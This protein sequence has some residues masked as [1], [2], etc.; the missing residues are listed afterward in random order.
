MIYVSAIAKWALE[1]EAKGQMKL[2]GTIFDF[3]YET[4]NEHFF[5]DFTRKDSVFYPKGGAHFFYTHEGF[6]EY[7]KTTGNAPWPDEVNLKPVQFMKVMPDGCEEYTMDWIIDHFHDFHANW[8]TLCYY[9]SPLDKAAIR[10]Q[11]GINEAISDYIPLRYEL[12]D[13]R[14]TISVLMDYITGKL[15]NGEKE[16]VSA[17]WDKRGDVSAIKDY[18]FQEKRVR[19]IAKAIRDRHEEEV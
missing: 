6:N 8:E 12:M 7:L 17:A 1:M 18:C 4:D 3:F 9:Y 11:W 19:E 2:P 13:M 14:N 5:D 15:T 10:M 16:A